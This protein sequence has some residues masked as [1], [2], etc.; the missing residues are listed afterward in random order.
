MKK[1]LATAVALGLA[2]VSMLPG[3]AMTKITLNRNQT[4]LRTKNVLPVVIALGF[5]IVSALPRIAAAKIAFNHNQSLLR[6]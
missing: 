2:I 6:G 5:A 3:I 1:L 4:Q